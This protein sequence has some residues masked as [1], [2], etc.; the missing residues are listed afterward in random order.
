VEALRIIVLILHF[1]S[2]AAAFGLTIS[3]IAKPRIP[4]GLTHSVLSALI[5]GILLVGIREMSD[6][7][8]DMVKIATKLVI[9]LA[10]TAYTLW[11]ARSNKQ[12]TQAHMISLAIAIMLNIVVA[13]AV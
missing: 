4:A 9:A 7:D 8:V 5:T 6:L 12:L 2:W 3:A 1:V 13:V 10:I 11:L